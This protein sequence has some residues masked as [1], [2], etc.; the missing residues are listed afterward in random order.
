M[1][2]NIGL[3]EYYLLHNVIILLLKWKVQNLKTNSENQGKIIPSITTKWFISFSLS[4][5]TAN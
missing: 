2:R 1:Q 3:T 5:S 4:V